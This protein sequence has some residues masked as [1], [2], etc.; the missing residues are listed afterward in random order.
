[1][2][3][4]EPPT[5]SEVLAAEIDDVDPDACRTRVGHLSAAHATGQHRQLTN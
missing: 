5:S 3:K 4:T 2:M 1:M